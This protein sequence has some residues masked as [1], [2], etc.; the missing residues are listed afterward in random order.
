MKRRQRLN[1]KETLPKRENLE[2]KCKLKLLKQSKTSKLLDWPKRK[3][4][5]PPLRRLDSQ[6][7]N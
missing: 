1:S 3:L 7:N 4:Q 2:L 5:M 6:W